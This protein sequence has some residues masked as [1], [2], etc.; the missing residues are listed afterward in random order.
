MDKKLEKLIEEVNHKIQER[1]VGKLGK[2]KEQLIFSVHE[3]QGNNYIRVYG[4]FEKN[5]KAIPEIGILL[6]YV[7]DKGYEIRRN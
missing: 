5:M 2:E 3:E 6:D 7:K 4:D 1:P